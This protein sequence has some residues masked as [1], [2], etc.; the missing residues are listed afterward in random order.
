MDR[1]D[2]IKELIERGKDH[3]FIIEQSETLD[4][5][6][7]LRRKE[8]VISF[9][10]GAN[11]SNHIFNKT[12]NMYWSSADYAIKPW[13]HYCVKLNSLVPQYEVL[14]Q[15]LANQYRIKIFEGVTGL[16]ENIENDVKYLLSLF[17]TFG[18]SD[19]DDLRKKV[20]QWSIQKTKISKKLSKPAETGDIKIIQSCVEKL[21]SRETLPVI[22]E[23]GSAT[24]EGILLRAFIYEN[25]FALKTE[26]R[27]LPLILEI[28][29]SQNLELNLGFEYDKS[30][31]YQAIIFQELLV[32]WDQKEEINLVESNS[33]E[34]I[35]SLKNE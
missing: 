16:R 5:A 28:D 30:N 21:N 4:V 33:R 18:V 22:L 31:I 10:V 1:E 3:G 14:L 20:S 24:Q 8:P 7:C 26:H 17:N 9:L 6:W 12:M 11:E 34:K 15:N 19:I 32:E 29:I 35:L 2:L 25:G 13:S 27:N 23:I